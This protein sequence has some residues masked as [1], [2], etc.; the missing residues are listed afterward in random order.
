[1]EL[2]SIDYARLIQYAAQKQHM[3]LLNKTQINKILFYVYGVYLAENQLPLFMDDTPKAWTYGPVFPRP[4]KSVDIN[5]VI[6]SFPADKVK[7]YKAN[8]KA[9]DLVVKVVDRMYDKSAMSL[10]QWSHVENSPWYNT[11][12]QKDRDGNIIKQRPWNT[13][14]EDS[15]IKDYFPNLKTE[16]WMNNN[17]DNL[18]ESSKLQWYHYI[19]HLG[20]Y[21]PYWVKFFFG[22]PFKETK[23]DLNILDTVNTLLD[24][25]TTDDNI[26]KCKELI[27]LH[28]VVENTRARRRL[29]NG[30]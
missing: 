8:K 27:V 10:T 25:E 18:F 20:Y 7:A 4:N 13:R 28:R 9:L 1:M 24:S 15:L 16:F 6:K 21:I 17:G 5:E 19:I 29:E 23:K 12:Y 22:K 30:H 11:V 26:K 14:I 3:V 2:T